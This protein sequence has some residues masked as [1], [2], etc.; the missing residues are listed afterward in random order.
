MNS[1]EQEPTVNAVDGLE[2]EMSLLDLALVLAARKR[3]IIVFPLVAGILAAGISL[4]MPNIYTGTTRM[5]M[6]QQSQSTASAMLGQL[7]GLAGLAG[8]S[9]G[10]KNP[11]DLYVA[12]LKSRT[13][14]DDLIAKYKLRELW[15]RENLTDTRRALE[16]VTRISAG[17]DGLITVE[18]DDESPERAA[19]IA[20]GYVAEL[21]KLTRTLA[22][23]EAAQRRLFFEQ[24]LKKINADLAVAETGLKTTQEK[25]GLIQLDAQGEAIIKALAQLRAEIIATEVGLSAMGTFA[26]PGNPD[27]VRGQ[28]QL[29]S[30]KAQLAK[31]ESRGNGG[32]QA[33]LTSAGKVPEA[34]LEYVRAMREVKYQEAI[35][36]LVAKQLEAARMDEAKESAE[37]QVLD[38][39]IPPER[40]S[41]PKRTLI[42]ILTMLA[43]GVLAV[44]WAFVSEG[45]ARA[46]EDPERAPKMAALKRRLKGF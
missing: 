11:A 20:N 1:T 2:E 18:Y 6:P 42:V 24:H 36:V 4:L 44:L 27:Y 8:S 30:L 17:K 45:I 15:K 19:Q 21:Q 38:E 9:L 32:D 37:I 23:T 29:A 41:K 14:A 12:M 46:K 35:F 28:Q 26:T 16:G 31:M 43:A 5:L 3:L 10:I 34:G 7:G 13:V 33:V 25:T 22:V 40:K 39:A